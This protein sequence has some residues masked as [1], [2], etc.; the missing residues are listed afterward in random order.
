MKK[1]LAPSLKIVTQRD[2]K[3]RKFMRDVGDIYDSFELNPDEAQYLNEAMSKSGVIRKFIDENRLSKRF[4]AEEVPSNYGYLSG[5]KRPKDIHIQANRLRELFPGL[6]HASEMMEDPRIVHQLGIGSISGAPLA[7][8]WFAIPRWEKIAS[9]YGEAV[10]RVLDLINLTRDG[11][12]EKCCHG[13]LGLEN[14]R[15]TAKTAA[16]FKKI[17]IEQ[18]GRDILVF[19]AQFGLRHRGRSDRRAIEVMRSNE[20]G[21]GAFG[22]GIMLLT[23]LERLQRFNDLKIGCAGDYFVSGGR[24]TPF[25]Y[26]HTGN[27]VFDTNY[28]GNADETCGAASG[29]YPQA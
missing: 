1:S 2:P 17:S 11:K 19:P 21:L 13:V 28:I 5:Y 20:F 26:F 24:Y 10:Q 29:F 4:S 23:H 14:L 7:E 27:L 9:T 25:F 22:T 12:F 3:G 16:M 8:G 6:G 18:K 15:Q